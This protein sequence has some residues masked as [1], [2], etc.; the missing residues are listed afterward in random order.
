MSE[1]KKRYTPPE[2]WERIR[3]VSRE[4]RHQPTTSEDRLWQALRNRRLDGLKFRRQHSIGRFVADFYCFELRLAVEVDGPI[5]RLTREAD[6]AREDA[7]SATGVRLVRFTNE[8]VDR[9]I[10]DVLNV[11][12]A[13]AHAG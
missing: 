7:L 13:V 4:M 10:A 12:R 9:D 5:H 8:Q 11:I 6:A 3:T 2:L 1:N